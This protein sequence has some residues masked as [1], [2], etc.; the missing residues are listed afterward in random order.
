MFS[1]SSFSNTEYKIFFHR[2]TNIYKSFL[3]KNFS[4]FV[5]FKKKILTFC[6]NF[7]KKNPTQFF[8]FVTYRIEEN[9]HYPES[10]SISSI[11]GPGKNSKNHNDFR[12]GQDLVNTGK[13]ICELV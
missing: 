9:L 2:A 7:L 8:F 5:F 11:S 6:V 1:G 4:A 12:N 3:K 13:R 10:N